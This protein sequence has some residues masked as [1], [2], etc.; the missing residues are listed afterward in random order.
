MVHGSHKLRIE[1]DLPG[2]VALRSFRRLSGS[3]ELGTGKPC[4][5]ETTP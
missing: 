1:S 2:T 5:S 3:D 4:F